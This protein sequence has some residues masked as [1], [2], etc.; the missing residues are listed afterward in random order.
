MSVKQLKQEAV[1]LRRELER[2]VPGSNQYNA[3]Q[4]QLGAVNGRVVLYP[5]DT[6]K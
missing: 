1:L 2:V 5:K 3:L 4:T 6:E